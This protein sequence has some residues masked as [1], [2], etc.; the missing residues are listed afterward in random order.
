MIYSAT[1]GPGGDR[2]QYRY[3]L[4]RTWRDDAMFIEPVFINR[5]PYLDKDALFVMLNPST[6]DARQDDPTVAKCIRLARRWGFGGVQ[7]RNIFAFR[8][9]DP[10]NLRH[11]SD[12]IGPDNDLAI[13]DAANSEHTGVIVAAWGN[14]GK[15]LLRGSL[16]RKMLGFTG[17]PIYCF[18]ISKE[19]QPVHPLYQTEREL[20]EMKIWLNQQA[21]NPYQMR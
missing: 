9:T 2:S 11:A 12:P 14:D 21:S 17:R 13:V 18:D 4:G 20:W 6:A 16:V 3:T 8:S 15:F 19:G 5:P 10:G 7:V 1:F